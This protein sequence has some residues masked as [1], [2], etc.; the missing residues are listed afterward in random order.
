LDYFEQKVIRYARTTETSG[1]FFTMAGHNYCFINDGNDET[2]YLTPSVIDRTFSYTGAGSTVA[3]YDY[4]DI[5]NT[6]DCSNFVRLNSVL[7]GN[8]IQGRMFWADDGMGT[9][10]QGS[11]IFYKTFLNGSDTTISF[12]GS[13]TLVSAEW[14]LDVNFTIDYSTGIMTLS[15]NYAPGGTSTSFSSSISVV[16][17]DID[18]ELAIFVQYYST[19]SDIYKVKVYVCNTY[20]YFDYISLEQDLSFSSTPIIDSWSITGNARDIYVNV[21]NLPGFGDTFAPYE[22]SYNSSLYVDESTRAIVAPVISYYGVFWEYVQMGCT[23]YSQEV[24]LQNNTITVRDIGGSNFSIDN[25]VASP[26]ISPT[27]TLS[28]RQVNIAYSDSYFVDGIVYDAAADGNNIISVAAGQTTVTSVK[29]TVHPISIQQPVLSETWPIDAGEYYVIDSSGLRLLATEWYGYGGSVTV[30][31]DPDDPAAI[32][33]TVVGPYTEVTLA[34]GPYELAASTGSSKFASLKIAGTGVYAGDNVLPLTT[35]VDPLKYTR[36][37]VNSITNPFIASLEQAYDR[38]VW[39]S[40][41]ASGPVVNVTASVPVSS[42]AAIGET[43]GSL[44]QYRDSTYRIM[45]CSL[46][47]ISA[48]LGAENYVTVADVDAIWGSQTVADYD[49]LWD[50]Y[51]CQDQTIFP[52]KV[53]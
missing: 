2:L 1:Q 9:V 40:Q 33:I 19:A 11:G 39:A 22:Y 24:A 21:N 41:K 47:G 27:S 3:F 32:Q 42:I 4:Q 12:S 50:S 51:E 14:E 13:P 31:I 30:N 20:D 53:A 43:P 35:G 34:G 26:T 28:G 15:G 48:S 45:S 8:N 37:N 23:A 46:N 49:S 18:S 17:L 10:S 38:G 36:A 44:V 29:H 5:R 52:Y 16:G 7:Y 6:L 25:V